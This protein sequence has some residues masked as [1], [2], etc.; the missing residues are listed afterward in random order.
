[1]LPWDQLRGKHYGWRVTAVHAE[2]SEST[3][4]NRGN[5]TVVNTWTVSPRRWCAAR[6]TSNPNKHAQHRTHSAPS[7]PVLPLPRALRRDESRRR[8]ARGAWHP[9][10][11]PWTG[12]VQSGWNLT[13]ERFWLLRIYL[14][15]FCNREKRSLLIT[16]SP[17]SPNVP[18]W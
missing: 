17:S 10:R 5:G 3:E 4:E 7:P 15:K 9:F 16:P 13:R 6:H 11:H 12:N 18:T 1:M 2:Y 14:E 8:V